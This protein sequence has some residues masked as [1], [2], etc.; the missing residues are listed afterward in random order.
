MFGVKMYAKIARS[1]C[2]AVLARFYGMSRRSSRSRALPRA[3]FR[4]IGTCGTAGT[5]S[6]RLPRVRTHV[7]ALARLR[8]LFSLLSL[9]L[10]LLLFFL[11][12]LLNF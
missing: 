7:H 10:L 12:S 6:R 9:F 11:F 2:R 5:D 8:W 3:V 1:D 4:A